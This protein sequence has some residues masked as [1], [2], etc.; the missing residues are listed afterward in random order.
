LLAAQSGGHRMPPAPNRTALTTR[1]ETMNGIWRSPKLKFKAE[2]R[3]G[4]KTT[5]ST[6]NII[7]DRCPRTEKQDSRLCYND[8]CY[9]K[10][11]SLDQHRFAGACLSNDL[12]LQKAIFVF[13][14]EDAI[15]VSKI[16]TGKVN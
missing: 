2:T 16:D 9:S 11:D 4:Q 8:R 15:I 6:P 7:S 10:A 5:T 14:A 1:D 12:D 3:S 13:N